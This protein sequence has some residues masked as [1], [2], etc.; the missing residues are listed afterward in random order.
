MQEEETFFLQVHRVVDHVGVPDELDQ[1]L[2]WFCIQHLNGLDG[3]FAYPILEA[4]VYLG[5]WD[6]AL[7]H[8]VPL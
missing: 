8:E 1:G 7:E 3:V 2:V 4:F 6:A 5:H